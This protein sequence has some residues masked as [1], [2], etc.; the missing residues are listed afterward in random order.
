MEDEDKQWHLFSQGILFVYAGRTEVVQGNHLYDLVNWVS[1]K[2]PNKIKCK[3][4]TLKQPKQ[5]N[6]CH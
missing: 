4:T 5:L 2:S 6:K 1:W 3:M